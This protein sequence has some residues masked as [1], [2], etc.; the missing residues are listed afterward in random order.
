M[1]PVEALAIEEA[2]VTT[3]FRIEAAVLAAL[4]I[5]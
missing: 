5:A 1:T 3:G 4:D 2:G